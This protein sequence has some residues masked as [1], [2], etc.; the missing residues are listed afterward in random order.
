MSGKREQHRVLVV[1][2]DRD[3]ARLVADLLAAEGYEVVAARDGR[4]GLAMALK[5]HEIDLAIV[6][7]MLPEMEGG[8]VLAAIKELRPGVPVL[9]LTARTAPE[10][11]AACFAA[12]CDGFLTKPFEPRELA[13]EVRRLVQPFAR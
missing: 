7:L 4:E 13:A 6:D 5:R 12:G 11:A 10:D 1:D 3:V 2:D 8:E 9:V